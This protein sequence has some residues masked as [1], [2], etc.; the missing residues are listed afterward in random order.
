MGASILVAGI[1]NIF[2]GDDA[3]G[4]AVI[5]RLSTAALPEHVRVID[6]G[7]RSIDL[8]F[9]L[10]DANDLTILVDTTSRG[11]EPGMLYTIEIEDADIPDAC[12]EAMMTN[13][14]GLDPVRVL[15]MAKVMGAVFKK[16][17]LV[18]CEPLIVDRD[19]SGHIGLSD[20]VQAAVE[21]A[22]EI[23]RNLIQE[24]EACNSKRKK[25]EV[26]FP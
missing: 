11:G 24:F 15:S 5:Q 22:A 10:L 19:N 18:A 6:I 7:I 2:Q 12:D 16:T 20:V 8:V 21:P 23:V 1:G 13:S 25:E 3:F 26:C 17:L 4:V 9:A 14:H